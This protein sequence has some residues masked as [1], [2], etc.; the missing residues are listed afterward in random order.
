MFLANHHHTSNECA[1]T[2]RMMERKDA[3]T[4]S[5]SCVA[6]HRCVHLN[7]SAE[8][9]HLPGTGCGPQS[10]EA[11]ESA[12]VRGTVIAEDGTPIKGA[13]VVNGY[14]AMSSDSGFVLTDEK[15][16]FETAPLPMRSGIS[17]KTR[18]TVYVLGFAPKLKN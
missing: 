4:I 7:V 8:H 1:Q 10:L 18:L 12:P 2:T 14:G 5:P 13:M 6:C 15:G 16:N 11:V 17:G 3:P 9:S